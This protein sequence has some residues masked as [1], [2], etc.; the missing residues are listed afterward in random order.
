MVIINIF[1]EMLYV[2]GKF[3]SSLF[4]AHYMLFLLLSSNRP[5]TD[6]LSCF[7]QNMLE[8]EAK[9]N[10]ATFGTKHLPF[11]MCFIAY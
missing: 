7:K 4:Y 1:R 5:I 10:N 6:I 11:S 2:V 8:N 3:I 9:C